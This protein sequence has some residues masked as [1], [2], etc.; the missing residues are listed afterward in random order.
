[1]V[2][3]YVVTSKGGLML[4]NIPTSLSFTREDLNRTYALLGKFR[5]V[6]RIEIFREAADQ[7]RGYYT[8]LGNTGQR[9]YIN[10]KDMFRDMAPLYRLVT[11][12]ERNLESGCKVRFEEFAGTVRGMTI[13]YHV[14]VELDR[15]ERPLINARA[16]SLERVKT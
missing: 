10:V 2:V 4:S 13:D 8:S 11:M 15:V 1:M 14:Q 7:I 12:R 16:E 6:R 3:G 9:T 5:R